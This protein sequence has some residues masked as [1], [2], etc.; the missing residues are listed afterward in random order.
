MLS[1][2]NK[3]YLPARIGDLATRLADCRER[4]ISIDV[5]LE[6][7]YRSWVLAGWDMDNAVKEKRVSRRGGNVPL[8][9]MISRILE[10]T[11]Q[12]LNEQETR[13]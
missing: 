12:K 1:K 13:Q 8:M 6:F 4:I 5:S 7:Q 11:M 2:G 9:L 3:T 10:N